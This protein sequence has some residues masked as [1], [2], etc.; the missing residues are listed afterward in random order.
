LRDKGQIKEAEEMLLD[1]YSYLKSNAKELDSD[2]L[3]S[4][5]TENKQDAENLDERSW[6]RQRKVMREIQSSRQTQQQ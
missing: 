4:Y 2:K 6:K 1:N 3:E 5:A